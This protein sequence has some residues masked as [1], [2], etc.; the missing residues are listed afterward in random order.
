MINIES[1]TIEP[2]YT[3]LTSEQSAQL[4]IETRSAMLKMAKGG[5][6]YEGWRPY[7]TQCNT[8]A[9]MTEHPYGFSCVFCKNKIGWNLVRLIDSPLSENI[10]QIS[11]PLV[12][13]GTYTPAWAETVESNLAHLQAMREHAPKVIATC[14]ARGFPDHNV[15]MVTLDKFEDFYYVSGTLNGIEFIQYGVFVERIATTGLAIKTVSQTSVWRNSE[16][17]LLPGLATW[18]FFKVLL[19]INGNIK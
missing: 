13:Y 18:M 5:T 15:Y 9:R 3:S 6:W 17:K 16:Y 8:M 2:D 14:R 1:Q 11:M 12:T 7:C 4:P 10:M 19:P